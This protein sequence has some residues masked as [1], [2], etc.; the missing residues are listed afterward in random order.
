LFFEFRACIGFDS[1][2]SP[3]LHV[4]EG[5]VLV[6]FTPHIN[7]NEK[8]INSVMAPSVNEADEILARFGYVEATAELATV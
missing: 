1:I 4:E 2:S 7:A 3:E 5:V 8:G 6:L